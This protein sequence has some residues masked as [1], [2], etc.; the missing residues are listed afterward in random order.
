MNIQK[1]LNFA[2][3]FLKFRS[4]TKQEIIRYLEKKS[5]KYKFD[6]SLIPE[7]IRRL[8]DEG[9]INDKK[10]IEA[11]VHDRSLFKPRSEFILRQE[12]YKLGIGKEL[13]EE[14][15]V[16]NHIDEYTLAKDALERK[17]RVFEGLKE[18]ERFKKSVAYLMRKGFSYDVAKQ[19]YHSIYKTS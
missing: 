15:F 6:S 4:R 19:T 18:Q 10:F 17:K 2:Y 8:E 12:L 13:V 9:I 3:F 7:T 16:N 14:Y 11:Y 1:V 5:K